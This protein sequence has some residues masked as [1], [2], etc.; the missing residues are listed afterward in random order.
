MNCYFFLIK[1]VLG[2]PLPP[3]PSSLQLYWPFA[4]TSSTASF[5]LSRL[6]PER[7]LEAA[8]QLLAPLSPR[9]G[10]LRVTV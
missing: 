4:P 9:P 10:A 7:Q 3:P 2:W 8:P 5:S 1:G 6:A